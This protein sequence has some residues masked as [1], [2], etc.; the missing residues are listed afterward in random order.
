M[1]E[2]LYYN[3]IILTSK[4]NSMLYYTV[5][6]SYFYFALCNSDGRGPNSKKWAPSPGHIVSAQVVTCKFDGKL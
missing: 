6:N 2:L 5:I 3:E 1:Q 4:Q